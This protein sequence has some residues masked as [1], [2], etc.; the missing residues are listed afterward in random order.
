M[1]NM[2]I[3]EQKKIFLNEIVEIAFGALYLV[4][5][6]LRFI[7]QHFDSIQ[8]ACMLYMDFFI[9]AFIFVLFCFFIIVFS[10][11]FFFLTFEKNKPYVKIIHIIFSTKRHKLG[12]EYLKDLRTFK[13]VLL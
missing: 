4:M 2:K 5:T 9:F 3:H 8:I 6:F 1:K 10:C 13:L 7:Y 11:Y 12:T